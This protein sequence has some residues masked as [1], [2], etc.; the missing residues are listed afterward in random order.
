MANDDD[1]AWTWQQFEA[2]IMGPDTPRG[3]D[4]AGAGGVSDPVT[5]WEAGYRFYEVQRTLEM[6]AQSIADQA[7][8][9]AGNSDSP[10]QGAAAD[11][12]MTVMTTFSNHVLSCANVLSGYPDKKDSVPNQLVGNGN[13][14]QWAQAQIESIDAYY[15][16]AA[17]DADPPAVIVGG[18]VMVDDT[19]EI[20]AMMTNDMRTVF[21]QLVADY[22]VTVDAIKP[23]PPGEHMFY[24]S[25]RP[26]LVRGIRSTHGTLERRAVRSTHGV[27]ERRAV[28]STH[29]APEQYMPAQRDLGVPLM[30][31]ESAARVQDRTLPGYRGETVEDPVLPVYPA[32]RMPA[33]P[34]WEQPREYA[35]GTQYHALD[36]GYMPAEYMPQLPPDYGSPPLYVERQSRLLPRVEGV[37]DPYMDAV[38]NP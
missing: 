14:L 12:F 7:K 20:S 36:D 18:E 34:S 4:P 35:P 3:T 1:T 29:G 38:L 17:L 10:W 5:L 6:V 21:D 22:Q 9:L 28:K 23:P 30:P 15:S 32:D 11:A 13:H 8:A 19:P 26:A 33:L 25:T 24:K 37:V 16:Q 2:A 27:L 31:L